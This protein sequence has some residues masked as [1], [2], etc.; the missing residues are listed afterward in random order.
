MTLM[1]RSTRRIALTDV[2]EAYFEKAE[3]LLSD[4]DTAEAEASSQ[5]GEIGGLLRVSAPSAFGVA[6]LPPLLAQFGG[7][8][9]ALTV[10]IGLDD[11][12]VDL[13]E[14]R[15]DLA[16]RIG[17][18]PDSALVARK[19][20]AVR[21]C[22]CAAPAYLARYGVPQRTAELSAHNCLGY[23]LNTPAGPSR[24][25]F[26]PRGE[27]Q[28]TVRGT[29]HANNGAVLVR[30]ALAGQGLVYGPRFFVAQHL[31]DG[32][33]VEVTLDMPPRELGAIYAVTHPARRPD[34]KAR[35]LIDFLVAKVPQL[36]REW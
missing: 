20:A 27:H 11:R 5:S 34:A 26:G 17:Q 32:D 30:A 12:Y 7:E 22:I 36:A 4:F 31:A 35:A 24:W 8:H 25:S 33:L 10:E 1:R 2:G 14:E 28:V 16:I 29:L 18:L 6:S 19:L 13:L 23:T 3:R 21:L 15:W 9:P